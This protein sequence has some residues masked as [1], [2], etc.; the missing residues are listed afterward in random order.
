M[1]I[2]RELV[3][4]IHETEPR[5]SDGPAG[6][7]GVLEVRPVVEDDDFGEDF[8]PE[9]RER[10]ARLR[11]SARGSHHAQEEAEPLTPSSSLPLPL[12]LPPETQ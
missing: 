8:T 11:G 2:P 5:P 10:E 7:S 12:P 1:S 4:R 3:R 9:L 6:E